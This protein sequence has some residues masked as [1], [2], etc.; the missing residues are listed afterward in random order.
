MVSSRKSQSHS[1]QSCFGSELISSDFFSSPLPEVAPD[2]MIDVVICDFALIDF[3]KS[4][5]VCPCLFYSIYLQT[6]I[7]Q[8]Q[9]D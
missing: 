7:H 3:R 2:E 8:H 1:G 4:S 5:S 9:D 6:H